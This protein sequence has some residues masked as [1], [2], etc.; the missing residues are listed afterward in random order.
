M[1]ELIGRVAVVTGAARGVGRSVATRAAREGMC[2]VIADVNSGE[3]HRLETR[4]RNHGAE[5]LAIPTDVSRADSVA[6][7]VRRTLDVFGAVH[8]LCN[9]ASVRAGG[10][11]WAATRTQWESVLNVNLWGAIYCIQEFV[12]LMLAQAT[13]GHIVNA[14]SLEAF[15]P[16]SPSAPTQA[17]D[18]AVVALTENLEHGLRWSGSALHASVLCQGWAMESGWERSR[19]SE[20]A[21]AVFAGIRDNRLYIVP[22]SPFVDSVRQRFNTIAADLPR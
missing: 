5:V 20:V 12:P 8:L 11:S 6:G 9:M 3:L 22:D 10:L 14:A 19:A 18:A 4:L 2:V 17:T 16:L 1:D 15:L 13:P 21:G 7:L